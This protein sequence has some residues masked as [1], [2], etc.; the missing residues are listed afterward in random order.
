MFWQTPSPRHPLR[1]RIFW[2]CLPIAISLPLIVG[3]QAILGG[4]FTGVKARLI[5]VPHFQFEQ[6]AQ[7]HCPGDSIV[8]ATPESGNYNASA[9]RWYGQTGNGTFTCLL[10]AQKA[11]YRP[12]RIIR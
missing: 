11:G 7:Q 9:E 4:Y 12:T 2:S 8:W 1:R 3:A 10:D 5:E 6:Q